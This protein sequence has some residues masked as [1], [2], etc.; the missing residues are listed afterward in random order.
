MNTRRTHAVNPDRNFSIRHLG[1]DRSEVATMLAALGVDSLEQLIE[2]CVPNGIGVSGELNLPPARSEPEVIARLREI[3][4]AN[5]VTVPMIGMGYYN[6]VTP[7][8]V[9]RN[10]LENPA[11]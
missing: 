11:W 2:L 10:V 3:A 7:P 4:D 6:T 8:V 1:P 5:T 9:R